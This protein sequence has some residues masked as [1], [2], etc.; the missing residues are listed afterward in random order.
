[1]ALATERVFL[2][3]ALGMSQGGLVEDV[4]GAGTHV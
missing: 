3:L 2:A 1:M 4:L